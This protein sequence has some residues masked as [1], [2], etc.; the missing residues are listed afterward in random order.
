MA[1]SSN[2]SAQHNSWVVPYL[3]VFSLQKG[4]LKL[5]LGEN[6]KLLKNHNYHSCLSWE[7]ISLSGPLTTNRQPE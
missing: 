5:R 7:A 4:I 1:W 2:V 3:R 6:F